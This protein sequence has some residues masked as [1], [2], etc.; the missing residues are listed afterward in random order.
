MLQRESAGDKSAAAD[1]PTHESG[2]TITGD[3][4]RK[5]NHI[6]H[7]IIDGSGAEGNGAM[8]HGG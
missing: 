4:N 6:L 2:A 1:Q 5:H 7:S 8:Q 3:I